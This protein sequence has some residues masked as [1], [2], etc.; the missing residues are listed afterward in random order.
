VCTRTQ[1]IHVMSTDSPLRKQRLA[2]L[3]LCAAWYIISA[4]VGL[5]ALIKSNQ[6]Q[7]RFRKKAPPGV[8]LEFHI[9]DLYQP[10]VVL[11]TICAAT[12]LFAIICL[13]VTLVWP[14]KAICW[15]R[16]QAWIFIFFSVWILATQI[17]YTICTA[18]RHAKIDAFLDGKQ[19][20]AQT[21]QAALVAAGE[22]TKYS[23]LHFAVLLAICPW[24]SL[25]FSVALILI[26]FAAA[27]RCEQSSV[28]TTCQ[29]PISDG[30]KGDE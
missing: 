7:T 15:L 9:N 13:L 16:T 4:S 27:R 28:G 21:V 8:T 26:L 10:G 30:E 25:L 22:S 19:L 18:H 12:A 11:T 6:T 29:P 3:S 1:S 20:P 17:P 2:A 5:N 14:K 23:K 24:I